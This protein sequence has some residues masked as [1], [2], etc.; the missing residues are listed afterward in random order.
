MN[1]D[2]TAEDIDY[3]LQLQFHIAAERH[4]STKHLA[5]WRSNKRATK[6]FVNAAYKFKGILATYSRSHNFA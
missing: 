1:H 5:F 2:F 4:Y 3:M 6:G